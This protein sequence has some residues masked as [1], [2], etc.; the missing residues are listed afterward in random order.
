MHRRVASLVEPHTLKFIMTS[1]YAEL[2]RYHDRQYEEAAFLQVRCFTSR[3]AL[4]FVHVRRGTH[5]GSNAEC[6]C[7]A[8]AEIRITRRAQQ[9]ERVRKHR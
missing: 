1:V 5:T 4:S 2:L 3:H 8:C 9:Q 6:V 7:A